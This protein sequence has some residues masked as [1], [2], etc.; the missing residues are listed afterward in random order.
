MRSGVEW[1]A[2]A[3]VGGVG[4]WLFWVWMDLRSAYIN[5]RHNDRKSFSAKIEDIL[6]VG[7]S[8]YHDHISLLGNSAAF[9]LVQCH[10][11]TALRTCTIGGYRDGKDAN[12]STTELRLYTECD[13]QT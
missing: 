10:S 1:D 11:A 8:L 4:L 9:L 12:H 3:V 6:H 7:Q 13:F 2:E 5:H